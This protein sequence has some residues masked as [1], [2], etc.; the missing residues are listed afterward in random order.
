V[1]CGVFAGSR[2]MNR[3]PGVLHVHEFQSKSTLTYIKRPNRIENGHSHIRNQ[4]HSSRRCSLPRGS[5]R[6]RQWLVRTSARRQQRTRKRGRSRSSSVGV[7]AEKEGRRGQGREATAVNDTCAFSIVYKGILT[8]SCASVTN[9]DV[10][11]SAFCHIMNYFGPKS[12]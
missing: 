3:F 10:H 5:W 7:G 2:G 1:K 8:A 6:P 11:C 4:T 9:L 12:I